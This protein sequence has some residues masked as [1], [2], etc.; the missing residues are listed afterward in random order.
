MQGFI[1]SVGS[2]DSGGGQGGDDERY[3]KIVFDLS[4]I[5]PSAYGEPPNVRYS[6][7][8]TG[9]PSCYTVDSLGNEDVESLANVLNYHLLPIASNDE[10]NTGVT[11][12][13]DGLMCQGTIRSATNNLQSATFYFHWYVDLNQ[14][15]LIIKNN[16]TYKEPQSIPEPLLEK[17]INVLVD[18]T[19]I[20]PTTDVVNGKTYNKFTFAQNKL[21]VRSYSNEG[22]LETIDL[23]EMIFYKTMPISNN[24]NDMG[25]YISYDG[26][27]FD[28]YVLSQESTLTEVSFMFDF[29]Q[30]TQ[31]TSFTWK[32]YVDMVFNSGGEGGEL[33]GFMIVKSSG[34]IT[35]PDGV[36]SVFVTLVGGGGGGGGGVGG[37]RSTDS[38]RHPTYGRA[39]GGGGSGYQSVDNILSVTPGETLYCA[40]GSGGSGG[41][42]ASSGSTAGNGTSGGTTYIRRGS[43]TLF[44]VNGGSG[45]TGGSGY[46]SGGEGG[47][48]YQ[49]GTSPGNSSSSYS[50]GGAGGSGLRNVNTTSFQVYGGKGGKGGQS[51]SYY[52]SQT[53]GSYGS[54]GFIY[55]G[56]G[57]CTFASLGG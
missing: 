33:S 40:I 26:T 43:S 49:S 42:Y 38:D 10:E 48:G 20:T 52:I 19:G 50:N 27:T 22:P 45:G 25:I 56:W 8:Y 51:G 44:T 47:T 46:N 21:N 34:N 2:I 35:I 32:N 29:Y 17:Y 54:S 11:C 53:S 16:L 36:S 39:G 7:N 24:N 41:T 9:Y 5:T 14:D 1:S 30:I 13:F 6:Y 23:S 3:L 55:I 18:L 37:S 15:H 4:N 31:L 28:G 12:E 57:S